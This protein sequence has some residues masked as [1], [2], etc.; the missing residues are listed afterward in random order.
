MTTKEPKPKREK[1]PK[2]SDTDK[3][4]ELFLKKNR[5][6]SQTKKNEIIDNKYNYIKSL[7]EK[8][9]SDE[10]IKYLIIQFNIITDSIERYLYTENNYTIVITDIDVYESLK[11]DDYS[12][13]QNLKISFLDTENG[14]VHVNNDESKINN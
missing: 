9:E 8:L 12:N 2:L 11:L 7:I 10:N 5:V 13:Y 6:F 14:L 1:K 4:I 3:T